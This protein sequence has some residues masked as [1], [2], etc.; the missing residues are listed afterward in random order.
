MSHESVTTVRL[1]QMARAFTSSAALFAAIDLELFTAIAEGADTAESF[2]ERAGISALNAER[3]MTMCAAHG[4]LSHR[5]GRYANAPDV[6]RFL[7]KGDRYAGAWLTFL[8]PHWEKW[9]RLTENLRNT[10][11]AALIGSLDGMTVERARA[12]HTATASVGFGAG[13]RFARTVDLGGRKRLLDLGG[14]SGAYS[15]EAVRAYPGLNAVVFDLPPVVEV[16]R[17]FI[18]DAGV[19][20]RVTTHGGDFTRDPLPAPFDAAVMASNL[21]QYG[22]PVIAA[23][24]RRVHDVLEAGGEFHLVGEMLDDDRA[25]P[26][27]AALWGLAET[28]HN[29]TG[30][31][32]TRSE[33]VGYL[34]S[35]GFVDVAIHE[36][37]PGILTRVSGRKSQ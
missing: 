31:A 34:E 24:V 17:E 12:Y 35:A 30:R 19:A 5:H 29:S 25:G 7:V 1:Q 14:G 21:P 6:A 8:R 18:D 2:A 9:G 37:I 4:L 36:F 15:I 27:D 26:A 3:L 20:D 16:T 11:P 28:I 22:T 10:E 23:V 33:C 32:H 13:R